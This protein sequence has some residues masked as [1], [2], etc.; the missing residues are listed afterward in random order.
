MKKPST[1]PACLPISR[2]AYNG[3]V[4]RIRHILGDT[5]RAE[6]LLY[7]LDMYL[8]GSD[9]G[10]ARLDEASA[11]SFAFLRQDVDAAVERSRKARERAAKRKSSTA[12]A[13]SVVTDGEKKP[14]VNFDDENIRKMYEKFKKA[15]SEFVEIVPDEDNANVFIPPMTRRQRRAMERRQGRHS[16]RWD[17]LKPTA[18]K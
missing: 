9:E 10:V 3:F 17:H 16:T 13:S 6:A 7:A 5:P 8:H 15:I 2:K 12:D 11:M 14:A 4:A 1:T 18:I